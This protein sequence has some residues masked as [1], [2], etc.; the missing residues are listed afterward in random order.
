MENFRNTLIQITQKGMGQG[1]DEL[2][3]VLLK[4]YLTLLAEESEMPRVIAFYNGGV[5]LICSGSPVIEQLK[6]LEKKGVRLLA[7]K[8]CLKYYDLLEKRETGIEGTMMDI[9]ELQKVA[10]KVINL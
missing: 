2:G 5:Q 6:V 4:N 7:C 3:L 8:T 10:E 9:I 1:D